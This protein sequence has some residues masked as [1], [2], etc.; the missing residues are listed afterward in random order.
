M[1]IEHIAI[2]TLHLEEMKTFYETYFSAKAGNQ[3]HNPNKQFRSYFLSFDEGPRMELMHRPGMSQNS[4][5]T[6]LTGITHLAF[7]AGSRAAV[8]QLTE[9]LRRE[10]YVVAGEPRVT[11]DGY[12]ESVILDPDGNHIE[13]TE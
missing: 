12:Y 4:G 5:S 1:K 8:D 6:D 10:G 9:K 11:G 3:Y 2:W 13:I 7:S